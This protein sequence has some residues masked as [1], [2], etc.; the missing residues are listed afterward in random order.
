MKKSILDKRAVLSDTHLKDKESLLIV[1]PTLNS[2]K[3]LPKL[4]ES[5]EQQKL[6]DWNLLFIDGNSESA[7]RMWI[8]QCCLNVCRC[9]WEPQDPR[10]SGIFGAMNQG[11]EVDARLGFV[12]DW[13]MFWGSDDWA[14]GPDVFADVFEKVRDRENNNRQLGKSKLDLVVCRGR[15]FDSKGQVP[16]RVSSFLP[17]GRINRTA[18]RNALIK[19]RT[20]PHQGAMIGKRLR[21]LGLRYNTEYRLSADLDYFLNISENAEIEI[22]CLDKEIVYMLTGGVSSQQNL[23]RLKEVSSAYKVAFPN[24]WLIPFLMRYIHR[25]ITLVKR[26]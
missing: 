6:V 3:Y 11:F 1:V 9:Y 24:Q 23:K 8:E 5:L 17:E 18:Y 13:L 20:P 12:H 10:H 26:N 21:R 15:Y 2:H 16:T 4:V 14:I 7:H 19:G 22:L 25:L